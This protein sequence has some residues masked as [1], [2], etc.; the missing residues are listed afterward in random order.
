MEMNGNT[1]TDGSAY[2]KIVNEFQ[3]SDFVLTA[4]LNTDGVNLYSSSK[5]ELWPIFLAINELNPKAMFSR[6]NLLLI[7]IWQGKGKPPFKSY[8]KSISA[9]LKS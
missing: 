2:R 4:L 1:I 7:E 6:E 5:I 9:Q 8:F 3:G